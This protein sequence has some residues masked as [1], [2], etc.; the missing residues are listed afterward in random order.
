MKRK[1]NHRPAVSIPSSWLP[2][3]GD[4]QVKSIDPS[5]RWTAERQN[6]QKA[7]YGI[8]R[9]TEMTALNPRRLSDASET[10]DVVRESVD[11]TSVI[12]S[13]PSERDDADREDLRTDRTEVCSTR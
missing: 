10:F 5:K 3:K 4:L 1:E 6:R 7:K 11:L 8:D 13:V 2:R 12:M 9:E